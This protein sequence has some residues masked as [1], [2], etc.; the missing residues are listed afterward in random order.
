MRRPWTI[1]PLVICGAMP[2]KSPRIP[3]LCTI[4]SMTSMKLLNGLPFRDGGGFDCNPTFATMSGWVAMVAKD[5]EIA[6]RTE[7]ESACNEIFSRTSTYE[8]LPM[9]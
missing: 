3:S 1:N 9:V 7:K 6:P 2:L 8:M 4:N 5:F